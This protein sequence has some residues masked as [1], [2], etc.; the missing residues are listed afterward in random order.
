MNESGRWRKPHKPHRDAPVPAP[1][2]VVFENMLDPFR[3]QYRKKG[4]D[5]RSRFQIIQ[6]FR[7]HWFDIRNGKVQFFGDGFN[8][9]AVIF[10]QGILLHPL[11]LLYRLCCKMGSGLI[12]I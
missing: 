2:L 1:A 3:C 12:R 4:A 6:H 7:I 8:V 10:I 5:A 9:A 11:M